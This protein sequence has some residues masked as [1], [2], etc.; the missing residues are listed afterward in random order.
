MTTAYNNILNNAYF[1][2]TPLAGVFAVLAVFISCLGLFG[3]ASF[4]AER[5]TKEMEYARCSVVASPVGW[6]FMHGRLQKY[7]YRI[8]VN[9][10]IFIGA[11]LTAIIMSLL[12]ISFQIIR[13]AISNPIK[14][15][16]SE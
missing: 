5:R 4:T 15:L 11:A 13:A 3:L 6:Y 9:P 8:D 12:T 16:R 2:Y 10:M 7:G 1:G 14:S